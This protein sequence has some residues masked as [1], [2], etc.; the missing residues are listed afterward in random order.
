MLKV[1]FSEFLGSQLWSYEEALDQQPALHRPRR[2]GRVTVKRDAIASFSKF[3]LSIGIVVKTCIAQRFRTWSCN[4]VGCKIKPLFT[5]FLSFINIYSLQS[6][7][8]I[9]SISPHLIYFLHLVLSCLNMSQFISL[10]ITFFFFFFFFS[11][12]LLLLLL[13][14]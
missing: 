7:C 14:W 1:S 12:L 11:F 5:M 9:S 8:L 4:V 3:S 2:P 13:L 6:S 10:C